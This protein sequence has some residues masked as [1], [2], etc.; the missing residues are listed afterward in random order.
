MIQIANIVN[1]YGQSKP[2]VRN[3]FTVNGCSSIVGA[4]VRSFRTEAEMLLAWRDFVVATDPD[5]LTGYN[6]INFD[7][8]YLLGRAAALKVEG[9]PLLGRIRDS[10][11]KVKDTTFSSKA[12]GTREGREV[13]MD[14]RVI[15]DVLAAIQRVS[16]YVYVI[17]V[18]LC[19]L[20]VAAEYHWAE[21][22]RML[23]HLH[24]TTSCGATA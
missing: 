17:C 3:V 7:L 14:G 4:D 21:W 22:Q 2:V 10:R 16:V 13:S 24:R 5:M 19:I 1:V 15:Y 8:P 9:F 18:M 20:L 23:V 11:T 12:Y 6:I